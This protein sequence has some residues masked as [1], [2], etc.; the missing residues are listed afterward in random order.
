M[1]RDKELDEIENDLRKATPYIERPE[2]LDIKEG[3]L[4]WLD[5]RRVCGADCVSFNV[6]A[7]DD[8]GTAT[9]EPEKCLVLKYMGMQAAASQ[10]MIATTVIVNKRAQ[11]AQRASS[12]M[13]MPR[14]GAEKK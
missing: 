9:D 1:S 2:Q 5:G 10:A 8:S 12:T 4:C 3:S 11:D 13:P 6:E 7:L 14:T